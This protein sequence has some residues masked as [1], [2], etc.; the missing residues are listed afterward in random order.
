MRPPVQMYQNV[1]LKTLRRRH[2]DRSGVSNHQPHDCLLNRLFRH[3][4]KK[5]SKLH[6]TG[7][8][9]G[10]SPVTGE[11]PAQRSS[12]AENVSIWWRH[13]GGVNKGAYLA[14]IYSV[15]LRRWCRRPISRAIKQSRFFCLRKNL[16]SYFVF[17]MMVVLTDL[18][19]PQQTRGQ[20]NGVF[21]TGYMDSCHCDNFM[22]SPWR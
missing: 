16:G 5:T 20:R 8:C 14:L 15:T 22:C 9:E 7:L 1:V 19:V 17:R 4:S 3:R 10:N 18:M 2:N 13:H 11:F 6:A 21:V 12:N